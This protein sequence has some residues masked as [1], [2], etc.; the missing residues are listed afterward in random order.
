[1]ESKVLESKLSS[2]A[3]YSDIETVRLI[4][5]RQLGIPNIRVSGI[6]AGERYRQHVLALV[7][8]HR[9]NSL[10][11]HPCSEEGVCSRILSCDL[12][13]LLV[14]PCDRPWQCGNA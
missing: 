2:V 12:S 8:S 7:L 11:L 10:A 13:S 3:P 1:M 6:V 5:G 14:D 9:V 4:T